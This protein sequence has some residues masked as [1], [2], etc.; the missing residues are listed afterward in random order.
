MTSAPPECFDVKKV[1]NEVSKIPK[2]NYAKA[3]KLMV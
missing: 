1:R 2:R 3:G